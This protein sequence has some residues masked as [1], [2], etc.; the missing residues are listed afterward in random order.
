MTATTKRRRTYLNFTKENRTPWYS[1]AGAI[2]TS[3]GNQ[4]DFTW[5]GGNR[6]LELQQGGVAGTTFVTP[7]ITAGGWCFPM[8]KAA[9]GFE[10]TAGIVSG[11]GRSYVVGTDPAFYIKMRMTV[12]TI[13]NNVEFGVGFRKLGAYAQPADTAA[14]LAAYDD[15]AVVTLSTNAAAFT[16]IT[17]KAT[18]DVS[19][20]L[21]LAAPVATNE[22]SMRVDVSAAGVVTYQVGKAATTVEPTLAADASAVAYTF[23]SALE[24]VP[25]LFCLNSNA[26]ATDHIIKSLEWGYA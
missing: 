24:L 20:A 6:Y 4:N 2:M 8:A 15:K 14:A 16:T 12:A 18:V 22:V 21:T 7:T 10:L 17:S 9:D 3:A 25:C 19:T 26:A 23:T 11:I 1:A 13:A 5:V